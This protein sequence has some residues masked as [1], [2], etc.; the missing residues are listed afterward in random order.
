MVKIGVSSVSKKM[1]TKDALTQL[2]AVDLF[3]RASPIANLTGQTLLGYTMK[4]SRQHR[5]T[6]QNQFRYNMISSDAL[7]SLILE[8]LNRYHPQTR[9]KKD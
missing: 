1:L 4:V 6:K 7:R 3:F 8:A 5:K 9:L 2:P